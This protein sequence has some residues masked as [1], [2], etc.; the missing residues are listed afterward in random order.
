MIGTSSA[1]ARP[2][3]LGRGAR[4]GWPGCASDA[5]LAYLLAKLRERQARR[6]GPPICSPRNLLRQFDAIRKV[7][8]SRPGPAAGRAS[9]TYWKISTPPP[10]IWRA[11]LAC[12]RLRRDSN[13]G[14]LA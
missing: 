12:C 3:H 8:S 1:S 10:R 6:A 7:W 9:G 13:Y 5:I 2:R 4:P 11:V 14:R